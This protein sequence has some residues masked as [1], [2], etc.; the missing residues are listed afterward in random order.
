[1]FVL[2]SIKYLKLCIYNIERIQPI[3][4]N[5]ELSKYYSVHSNI[6]YVIILYF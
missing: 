2:L 4:I 1:M 3:F 5:N 6:L